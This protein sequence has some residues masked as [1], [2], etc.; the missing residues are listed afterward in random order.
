MLLVTLAHVRLSYRTLL[1]QRCT[2]RTA[3]PSSEQ[4]ARSAHY[5]PL[6]ATPSQPSRCAA[7]HAGGPVRRC[8]RRGR[9]TEW[10][11]PMPSSS[12]GGH[13]D[14][15]RPPRGLRRDPPPSRDRRPD[16]R[17]LRPAGDPPKE[18]HRRGA[19]SS[20]VLLGSPRIVIFSTELIFVPLSWKSGL[21]A[22][23]LTDLHQAWPDFASHILCHAST[24]NSTA[25]PCALWDF[26][27]T[28]TLSCSHGLKSGACSLH[29]RPVARAPPVVAATYS[30]RV[31][32]VPHPADLLFQAAT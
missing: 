31:P 3:P 29:V 23:I 9:G 5:T 24:V 19:H 17:R 7:A 1:W 28:R 8:R 21:A 27:R 13:G 6:T 20:G 10:S 16:L 15:H 30:T 2:G 12:S 32:L 18:H 4:S 26:H 25:I 11:T 14:V 22:A